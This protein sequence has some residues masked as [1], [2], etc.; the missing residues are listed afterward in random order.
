MTRGQ[1]PNEFSTCRHKPKYKRKAWGGRGGRRR[2]RGQQ[3]STQEEKP[4]TATQALTTT[5][6][7]RRQSDT[8]E[9][10]RRLRRSKAS[11]PRLPSHQPPSPGQQLMTCRA[12]RV[13]RT[14]RMFSRKSGARVRQK[15][16]KPIHINEHV[17]KPYKSLEFHQ[18]CKEIV[19]QM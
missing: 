13:R 2:H 16:Q 19:T 17:R 1:P 4:L 15:R 14:V 7:R 5:T 18:M 8:T 10:K 9:R 3:P 11:Y 6:T 12:T